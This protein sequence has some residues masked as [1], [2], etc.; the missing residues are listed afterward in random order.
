M[1]SFNGQRRWVAEIM[2]SCRQ[3]RNPY[4][5]WLFLSA[6]AYATALLLPPRG[7]VRRIVNAVMLIAAAVPFA[8]LLCSRG[9]EMFLGWRIVW[10]LVLETAYG[11]WSPMAIALFLMAMVLGAQLFWISVLDGNQD[12]RASEEAII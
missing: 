2:L 7:M 5:M 6:F 3:R 8:A 9:W 12:A 1:A 10:Y 4:A 11:V